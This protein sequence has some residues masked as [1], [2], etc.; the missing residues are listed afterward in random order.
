MV[1]IKATGKA[2]RK[3]ITVIELADMFPNKASAQSWLES[4]TW[5]NG[6]C[7]PRCD[8][9]RTR[10]ASHA[11]MPHWCNDCRSYFS[12]K[13]GTV[14]KS[15]KL[16]LRKW[17]LAIYLHLTSLKGVSSMKLHRDIG[18]S[19]PTAWFMF[20][21]IGKAFENDDEPPFIGPVEI[22]EAYIGG[23]DVNK[24]DSRKLHACGGTRE[25]TA[26]VGAKDRGTN[27]VRRMWWR[28]R[29]NPHSAPSWT[30]RWLMVL[31]PTLREHTLTT[32]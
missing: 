24:L 1:S 31:S 29:T 13:T 8:S 14:L 7:C 25:K 27:R 4:K 32:R 19:Q 18:V 6:R 28:R 2:C 20:Q 11:E 15:S 30:P 22:D 26:I 3:G 5:A 16:P 12:V 23:K 9:L 10:E 21:R 17:V